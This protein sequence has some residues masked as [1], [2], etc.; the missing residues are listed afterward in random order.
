MKPVEALKK[1]FGYSQFRSGQKE[2]I[3]SI[4]KGKNVLAVLPTGAG[5][6]ICYQI[7]GLISE[8]FSIVISPLIALMKDQVDALNQK[9]EVSAF[10]NSTLSFSETESILQKLNS[11]KVKLLYVAPERLENISFA[12]R[13]K[14]LKPKFIFVDEAHCISEWGHN[15]RPSYRSIKDFSKYISVEKISAFT[16]TATPEVIKDIAEQ[17][18]FSDEEIFVRGFER[19]NL[20]LNVIAAKKKNEQSLSLLRQYQTPAII[21]TA[22]RRNAEEVAEFL[23][24]ARVNCSF[25]HAGIASEIRKKIQEDFLS[26]KI[27][28]IAST[29]AF[30]MGI[31]KKDIRLIIH[32]NMPGSIEN[33]YQEIGR[34]GRDGK[35]SNVFLLY[36]DKDIKIHD[37]FLSSSNPS[38]QL[39]KK[40]YSAL[41][42]FGKVAEG[43]ISKE[44]IPVVDEYFSKY[45]NKELNRGLILTSLKILESA[46]Y[47]KLLTDFERK[48]EIQIIM[49]KNR[50]RE[51]VKSTL[52]DDLKDIVLTLLRDYG[53]EIL[54]QRKKISQSELIAKFNLSESELDEKLSLLDTMGVI[55]HRKSISKESV[56]ITVPRVNSERLNIAFEMLNE[57]FLRGKKKIDSMLQYVFTQNCRFKFILDYF[58]EKIDDYKCGKCDNCSSK[59]LLAEET[60]VYLEELIIR[61]LVEYNSALTENTIIDILRGTNK[62]KNKYNLSTFGAASNYSIETLRKVFHRLADTG[63]IVRSN[64]SSR[65]F[66]VAKIHNEKLSGHENVNKESDLDYEK[67]LELFNI[68]RE[69]RKKA[70]N[71]YQQTEYLICPDEILRKVTFLKPRTKNE[72]LNLPGF[73]VRMYH[74][75][76]EEILTA[77]NHFIKTQEGI[78]SDSLKI[79]FSIRETYSLLK[80]GYSLKDISSLR[81]LSEEV[82]SMQIETIL[83]YDPKINIEYLFE[84]NIKKLIIT[85]M[86][87]RFSN[88]KD[89]KSRLPSNVTYGMIRIC[90]ARERITSKQLSSDFPSKLKF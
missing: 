84:A 64:I 25:Y 46:G 90:I 69:M 41:C 42:D 88:L 18:N 33:Y 13:I 54:L 87:K 59:N 70:A 15:F 28:V 27:P 34:A 51:L 76:G 53:S 61:T 72:I 65:K 5:K 71:R 63:K 40:I 31:D 78:E 44:P 49:E 11:H 23:N 43:S 79:P 57:N 73:N 66:T 56:L 75:I 58:G 89:L 83:E 82:I 36:D 81:K 19:E 74:K 17:L 55:F 9:G 48:S 7:P 24:L 86:Q 16:A 52:Q 62:K 32:Y 67:N 1:Y 85:E 26:D 20:C 21:Y 68:L 3:D 22:S 50:L 2:I 30:G 45:C 12:E 47:L 37:Y 8:N 80:K 77:V 29:N 10:I 38:K 39:I 4:M 35:L 60:A 14:N 6:S